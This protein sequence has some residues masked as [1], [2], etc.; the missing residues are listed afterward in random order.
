[1]KSQIKKVNKSK[2][3]T[4]SKD[5]KKSGRDFAANIQHTKQ[6]I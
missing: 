5:N 2:N 1:M 4:S 3:K 6:I